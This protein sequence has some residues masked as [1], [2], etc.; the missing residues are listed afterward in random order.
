LTRNGCRKAQ[1]CKRKRRDTQALHVD[2]VVRFREW[3]A[4]KEEIVPRGALFPVS[5]KFTGGVDRKTAK[6][7]RLDL[8]EKVDAVGRL[9]APPKRPPQQQENQRSTLTAKMAY[10]I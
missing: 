10:S 6:M 5:A 7:M 9:P 4:T 2:V 8:A 3:L 1:F